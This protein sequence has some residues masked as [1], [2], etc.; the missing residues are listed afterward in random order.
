MKSAFFQE[1]CRPK[2]GQRISYYRIVEKI[3]QNGMSTQIK[4]SREDSAKSSSS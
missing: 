3:S 4:E 2:F 1:D